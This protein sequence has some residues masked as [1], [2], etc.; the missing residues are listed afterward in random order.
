M[1]P[2]MRNLKVSTVSRR[3]EKKNIPTHKSVLSRSASPAPSDVPIRGELEE[4][5]ECIS[6]KL[7]NDV[8]I[9]SVAAAS[10]P[11]EQI[12]PL[13]PQIKDPQSRFVKEN[14]PEFISVILASSPL[15]VGHLRVFKG[16]EIQTNVLFWLVD[17]GKGP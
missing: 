17:K 14:P 3:E 8:G 7:S 16:H 4:F 6:S 11:K 1:I 12:S 5:S 2:G 13:V 10:Y 15:V 9:K